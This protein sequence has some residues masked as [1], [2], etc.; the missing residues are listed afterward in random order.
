MD[1]K[2]TVIINTLNDEK[3][4]QRAINSVSWADEVLI[5]DMD[6]EDETVKIAKK[7][8][9]KVVSH[10][11]EKYVELA[12][13]FSVSKASCDWVLILDP[14]EEVSEGLA[15][16]IKEMIAKPIVSDYVEIPR[17]NIIFNKWMKASGW[18]PDYNIRLFRK[19]S[20]SWSGEIHR[21]PEVEG[22]GLK[23]PDEENFAIIHHHYES[24]S[25]FVSR[26]NRYTD[27]QAKELATS[28]YK[29]NW[30]DVINKPIGEFMSRYFASR[31]FEDGLHGLVLSFLQAFSF[32]V[33]YLKLWELEK[34]KEQNITLEDFKKI[35]QKT[36]SEISY[37]FK[38]ANLSKNPFK[39]FVQ[40][41]KNKLS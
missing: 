18:W 27:A 41:I 32:L 4:I 17:K 19:G 14:D 7:A 26:M 22:Q 13:N 24:I 3:I 8:G 28:D 25:Q 21:Q 5:C 40:K 30:L 35:S 12:R 9:A 10:K 2:I 11:R 34:F 15:G 33:L 39:K 6:S 20:A 36:G 23:L 29:F 16:R 1:K 31:G 38:Y 37:W